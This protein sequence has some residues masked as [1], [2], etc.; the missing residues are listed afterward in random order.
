MRRLVG[1]VFIRT[2]TDISSSTRILIL[3]KGF[4]HGVARICPPNAIALPALG[5]HRQGKRGP[6]AKRSSA[7]NSLS[8]E[9]GAFVMESLLI[10]RDAIMADL[11]ELKQINYA[12]SP[13]IHSDRLH[14]AGEHR[15]RYL[16]IEQN[17]AILGFSVLVF[18][19]PPSWSDADSR[20][21]LP[22]IV[23][24][25]VRPEQRGKGIGSCFIQQ[26][27]TLVASACYNRIFVAV[28]PVDNPKAHAL[29]LRLGYQP[30]QNE[31]YRLQW[32]LTDSD[33][34]RHEGESWNIDLVRHLPT[35]ALK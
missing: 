32:H 25:Y 9:E 15:M 34:K 19:R 17:E 11:E 5:S 33:G 12:H 18:L 22:Q 35:A 21:H 20:E 28:D 7:R 31:P 29:Y 13:A 26:M 16:V 27:E 4:Y 10:V 14:D 30:L 23:D 1:I 2:H 3:G 6:P 8:L 24:L